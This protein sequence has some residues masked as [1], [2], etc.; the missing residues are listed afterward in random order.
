MSRKLKILQLKHEV[1]KLEL[2][3]I[4]ESMN[5][6]TSDFDSFF[7]KYYVESAKIEQKQKKIEFENPNIH[8]ENAKREREAKERE[9]KELKELLKNAPSKVKKLYKSLATKTHPDKM[10][11]DHEVFQN[12]K[13]AYEKQDLAEML[14]MAGT[15]GV[16]YEMDDDDVEILEKNLR[17]LKT[18]I[19][20]IKDT[21]G[22]LWGT[23]TT[24]D[25]KFCVSRVEE[26]TKLKVKNE[27]LPEDLQKEET[28]LIGKRGEDKEE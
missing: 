27:D 17:K 8:F 6:Y 10:G 14:E 20:K 1:L 7:S 28:K 24:E 22:W 2:E 9:R 21:I 19:D 15:Y 26:E 16:K 13:D 11:G 23:G 3:E 25:R 5:R 12:V 18:E 4:S